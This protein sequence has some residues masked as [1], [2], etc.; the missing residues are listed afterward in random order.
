MSSLD[1]HSLNLGIATFNP[2]L[3]LSELTHSFNVPQKEQVIETWFDAALQ[4]YLSGSF[5]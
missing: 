5:N 2:L 4:N 3:I 1:F